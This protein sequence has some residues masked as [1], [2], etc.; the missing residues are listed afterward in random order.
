MMA[1]R[2]LRSRWTLARNSG[3]TLYDDNNFTDEP[4]FYGVFFLR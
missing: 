2:R 4:H 3:L 1:C